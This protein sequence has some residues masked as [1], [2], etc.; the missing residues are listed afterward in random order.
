VFQKGGIYLGGHLDSNKGANNK[1]SI[2]SIIEPVLN[3]WYKPTSTPQHPPLPKGDDFGTRIDKLLIAG[4]MQNSPRPLGLL[5]SLLKVDMGP[6]ISY[7]HTPRNIKSI[8]DEIGIEV[9][10][11][12]QF[13]YIRDHFFLLGDQS[14]G[15]SGGSE[16]LKT[17]LE[18]VHSANLYLHC[19][20]AT[21]TKNQFFNCWTGQTQT[22][23]SDQTLSSRVKA[24]LLPHSYIEGGNVFALTNSDGKQIFLM[25]ADHLMHTLQLLE[26]SN[27]DW[28]Q[29]NEDLPG[30]DSFSS[31]CKE[32]ETQLKAE[33]I[34]ELAEEMFASG[35]L[36]WK[37]GSGLIKTQKQLTILLLKYFS[38][39]PL[40]IGNEGR[41]WYKQLAEGLKEVRKFDP[42]IE[43]LENLRSLTASY[44][45][46]KQIVHELMAAELK[47]VPDHLH[48]II[49]AGYHLDTFLTPGPNGTI[50][51]T[52]YAL[53]ADLLDK[54]ADHAEAL[55]LSQDDRLLLARYRLTARKLDQE[56]SPLLD[57][58]KIQLEK[59][60]FTIIPMPSSF[61]YEPEFPHKVF[62]LFTQPLSMNF[63]NGISGWS[64]KLDNYYYITHGMQSGDKIGEII[65]N[66]FTIFLQKYIPNITLYYVGRDDKNGNYQEA[67][68]WWSRIDTQSGV[69]CT[70]WIL[71]IKN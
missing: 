13:G 64:D 48:F 65:M 58:A 10:E 5:E 25:G 31:R 60:N 53:A 24:L 3:Q 11:T 33:E 46:K 68:Q 63:A 22:K 34:F 4:E 26:L 15:T 7:I 57:L 50:F 35:L 55:L 47:I 59:A 45:I 6:E 19:S 70:T 71:N 18:R 30:K 39:N 69:H 37:E 23:N 2:A 56:L 29:L 62:P 32:M 20:P 9:E 21:Y 36:N 61:I 41:R 16:H 40:P 42:N 28:N 51:I 52:S 38:P 54:I 49:Q 66:L 44:A 67:M 1:C 14:T 43:E 8:A 17:A 27:C 12:N